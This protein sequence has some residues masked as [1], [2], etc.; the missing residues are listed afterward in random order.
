[1]AERLG[2]TPAAVALAW[3]IAQPGVSAAIAGSRNPDHVRENA[4]AGDLELDDATLA[5]LDALIAGAPS[6]NP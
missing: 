3:T 2:A 6:G 5:E 1:V 4:E